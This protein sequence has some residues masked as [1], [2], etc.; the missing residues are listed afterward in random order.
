MGGHSV[1]VGLQLVGC[2]RKTLWLS[3]TPIPCAG[4]GRMAGFGWPLLPNA[5]VVNSVLQES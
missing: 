5:N 1:V 4:R 3:H 2:R